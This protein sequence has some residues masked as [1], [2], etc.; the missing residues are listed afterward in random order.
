MKCPAK[1]KIRKIFVWSKILRHSTIGNV[2]ISEMGRRG[3]NASAARRKARS[4]WDEH[5][6]SMDNYY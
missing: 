2:E 5:N 3:T 6:G 4:E 1:E